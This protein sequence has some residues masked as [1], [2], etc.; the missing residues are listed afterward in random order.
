MRTR[1]DANYT[2]SKNRMGDQV[3]WTRCTSRGEVSAGR[4]NQHREL[5]D[6]TGI[7]MNTFLVVTTTTTT[8]SYIRFCCQFDGVCQKVSVLISQY[9][10]DNL[11]TYDSLSLSQFLILCAVAICNDIFQTLDGIKAPPSPPHNYL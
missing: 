2:G 6:Y 4:E 3:S 7:S 11:V 5:L 8:S 10:V 1:D 9:Y